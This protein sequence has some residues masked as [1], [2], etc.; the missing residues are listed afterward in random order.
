MEETVAI[1]VQYNLLQDVANYLATRPFNEVAG[2]ITA[3]QQSKGLTNTDLE[4][5]KPEEPAPEK[6]EAPE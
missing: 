1:L 4:K 3:L 5:L 2:L 6:E